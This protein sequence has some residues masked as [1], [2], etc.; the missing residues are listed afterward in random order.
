M[1][2]KLFLARKKF[3][4][5]TF[6]FLTTNSLNLTQFSNRSFFICV[7]QFF[8]SHRKFSLRTS[9]RSSFNSNICTINVGRNAVMVFI[10]AW[11]RCDS[12]AS[13]IVSDMHAN[14]SDHVHRTACRY[15]ARGICQ[16]K[17]LKFIINSSLSLKLCIFAPQFSKI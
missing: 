11:I 10:L 3:K 7:R 14:A 15:P 1:Y 9:N 13:D 6:N 16:S 5:K 17:F 2:S 8:A 4:K 12:R